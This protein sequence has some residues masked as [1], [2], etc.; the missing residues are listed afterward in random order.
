MAQEEQNSRKTIYLAED[1][2]DDRILFMEALREIHPEIAVK[3]SEDGQ[4]LLDNL[5]KTDCGKPEIIFLDINMPCQNGFECLKE[6][7][8]ASCFDDVQVIM[9]STSS[10]SIHIEMSR[11]LGA[12]F[13]AVKP[14]LFQD[15]KD[16][17]QQILEEGGSRGTADRSK[18]L[19]SRR[20]MDAF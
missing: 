7:R 14:G 8:S 5:D 4:Q 3:V 13:Y 16:L 9:L 11:K 19:L 10:S 18:F 2:E 20:R 15:L 6:I 1:D 17:L 12:D